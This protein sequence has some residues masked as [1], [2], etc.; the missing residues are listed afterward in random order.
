MLDLASLA[1]GQDLI[2][3]LPFCFD[4]VFIFLLLINYFFF[5]LVQ[6]PKILD[7]YKK[8]LMTFSENPFLKK[9][10]IRNDCTSA[11]FRVDDSGDWTIFF[12]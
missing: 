4:Y 11:G 8:N 6:F 3:A 5:F 9:C 2:L 12:T 7:E 10:Y 1:S